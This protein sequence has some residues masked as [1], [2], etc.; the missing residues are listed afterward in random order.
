M[1]PRA[2]YYRT[3]HPVKDDVLLVVEVADSSLAFD[4]ATKLGL[5]ARHG[6]PEVWLVDVRARELTRHR[7][8]GQGIYGSVDRVDIDAPLG[9]GR[10]AA[11]AV[12]LKG[13]FAGD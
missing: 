1:R 11:V 2:D 4:R 10:L 7:N 12:E 13:L 8:P 9:I 5:Y 3:A 6:V